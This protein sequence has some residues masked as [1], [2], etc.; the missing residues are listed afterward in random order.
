MMWAD[1]FNR[2]AIMEVVGYLTMFDKKVF[3][4]NKCDFDLFFIISIMP[5]TLSIADSI[6]LNFLVQ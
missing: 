6:S 2:V 1:Y 3:F 5:G 4:L